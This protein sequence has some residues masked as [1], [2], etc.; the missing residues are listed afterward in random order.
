MA[1][2]IIVLFIRKSI[3]MKKNVVKIDENTIRQ[4]VAES[5][6]KVL[7]EKITGFNCNGEPC[8][9]V[10]DYEKDFA[11]SRTLSHRVNKALY[12]LMV[13]F[14]KHGDEN[15][16]KTL[17]NYRNEVNDMTEKLSAAFYEKTYI[18]GN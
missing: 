12:D 4:I 9:E 10:E 8:G 13:F 16:A 6:K 7:S 14:K 1:N 11:E 18:S 3:F 2:Q 5:V 15:S 17:E